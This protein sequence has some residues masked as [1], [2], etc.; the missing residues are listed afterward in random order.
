MNTVSLD[1]NPSMYQG[2]SKARLK[3]VAAHF[4]YIAKLLLTAHNPSIPRIGPQMKSALAEMHVSN[5]SI[6]HVMF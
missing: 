3:V 1:R 4:L 6:F 5:Q 2:P